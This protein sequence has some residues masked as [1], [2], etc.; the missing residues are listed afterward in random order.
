MTQQLR[1]DV[2][3]AE[4]RRLERHPESDKQGQFLPQLGWRRTVNTWPMACERRMRG[5]LLLGRKLRRYLSLPN[6][7]VHS[8][9]LVSR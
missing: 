1:C 3:E 6:Y 4:Q 8:T 5:G 9:L 7:V 2:N